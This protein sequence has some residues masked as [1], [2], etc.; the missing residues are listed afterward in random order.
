VNQ[1]RHENPALQSDRNLEF[2]TIS[3]DQLIGFSKRTDDA[4]NVILVIVNIDPYRV[5]SGFL[6]L[7]LDLLK[8]DENVPYQA[9]DLVTGARYIWTGRRNYIE[10]NPASLPAHILRLRRRIRAENDFEYFV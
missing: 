10:L 2:H 9:H 1:I 4:D 7:S 3:N 5:Q 6:E 8:I